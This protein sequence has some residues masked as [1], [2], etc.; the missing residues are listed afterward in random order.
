MPPKPSQNHIFDYTLKEWVDPRT[1]SE[2]RQA[3]RAEIKEARN[4]ANINGFKWKTIKFDNDTDSR[5]AIDAVQAFIAAYNTFPTGWD[6][7]WEA[8]DGH[9]EPL[10]TITQW[11]NFYRAMVD[12]AQT[13]RKKYQS[14]KAS[15]DAATTIAEV[16]AIVW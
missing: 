7:V 16:D 9:D 10:T 15:I 5:I 14:R 12:D 11:N 1:L 8:S 13:V 4:K 2:A 3:K 6:G